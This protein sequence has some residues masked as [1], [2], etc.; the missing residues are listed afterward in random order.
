MQCSHSKSSNSSRGSN[1]S[2]IASSY[3]LYFYVCQTVCDSRQYVRSFRLQ[4]TVTQMHSNRPICAHCLYFRP[5]L[6]CY[7]IVKNIFI[8]LKHKYTM[9]KYRFP[10]VRYKIKC[11]LL[12][13]N[14]NREP[15]LFEMRNSA[16][17]LTQL[18]RMGVKMNK[19]HFTSHQ[20]IY[21][22]ISAISFNLKCK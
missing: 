8:Y 19:L 6:L 10:F 9:R 12:N 5:F 21:K 4:K 15:Q 1:I 14:F 3:V 13:E 16:I 7:S 11:V 22:Y 20:L 2:C 17:S 18:Q